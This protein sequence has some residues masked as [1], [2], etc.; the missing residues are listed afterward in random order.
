MKQQEQQNRLINS[1]N[2]TFKIPIIFWFL[3]FHCLST[4]QLFDLMFVS[5]HFHTLVNYHLKFKKMFQY[6]NT[7]CEQS[8]CSKEIE[9]NLANFKEAISSEFKNDLM[10]FLYIKFEISLMF[11]KL[12][13]FCL[14]HHFAFCKKICDPNISFCPM[15]SRIYSGCFLGEFDILSQVWIKNKTFTHQFKAYFYPD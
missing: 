1:S 5:K 15:C 14:F 13:L 3:V 7:I 10:L 8:V 2:L 12:S 9:K 4:I 6:V 11:V